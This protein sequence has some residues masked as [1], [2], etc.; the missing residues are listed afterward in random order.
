MDF[1][2]VALDDVDRILDQ[3]ASPKPEPR[4]KKSVVGVRLPSP[5]AKGG[6]SRRRDHTPKKKS[7][8]FVNQVDKVLTTLDKEGKKEPPSGFSAKKWVNKSPSIQP[9]LQYQTYEVYAEKLQNA[10]TTGTPLVTRLVEGTGTGCCNVVQVR[11]PHERHDKNKGRGGVWSTNTTREK[12]AECTVALNMKLVNFPSKDPSHEAGSRVAYDCQVHVLSDNVVPTIKRCD[13]SSGPHPKSGMVGIASIDCTEHLESIKHPTGEGKEAVLHR[14]SFVLDGRSL[15]PYLRL[16]FRDTD[17]LATTHR[18]VFLT[19]VRA[20]T[21]HLLPPERA[22]P[23]P[24]VPSSFEDIFGPLAKDEDPNLTLQ[25]GLPPT[26]SPALPKPSAAPP[27]PAPAPPQPAPAPPSPAPPPPVAVFP[28][29]E[30][31]D[32]SASDLA[33]LDKPIG[34]FR[35][36]AQLR[37]LAAVQ[38]AKAEQIESNHTT[39]SQDPAVE[40]VVAEGAPQKT[41]FPSTAEASTK[42]TPLKEAQTKEPSPTEA[43]GAGMSQGPSSDGGRKSGVAAKA[44]MP[45]H[46]SPIPT[47]ANVPTLTPSTLPQ[48]G[49][50]H[51]RPRTPPQNQRN[52]EPVRTSSRTA[53]ADSEQHP[54]FRPISAPAHE[55]LTGMA[56]PSIPMTNRTHRQS[57]GEQG[58]E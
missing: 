13:V 50:Q 46:G 18:I 11:E 21:F 40:H 23:P 58:D 10:K 48:S 31:V 55:S 28:E 33:E 8:D 22:K 15:Q 45:S 9:H 49:T 20:Q 12:A 44:P 26:S 4:R 42:K 14:Q 5:A 16:T 37:A 19:I 38:A 3:F 6:Q 51:T 52:D 1:N 27:Q 30:L 57:T 34:E 41:V 35:N 43:C 24:P 7:E 2:F 47:S 39:T 32:P 56:P 25:Y 36:S 53:S 29:P 54:T 17:V